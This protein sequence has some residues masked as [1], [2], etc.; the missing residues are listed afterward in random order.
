V[1]DKKKTNAEICDDYINR[2]KAKGIIFVKVR[3]PKD[4]RDDI[5]KEAEKMRLNG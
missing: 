4:K 5:L 1:S 2:N 3:V